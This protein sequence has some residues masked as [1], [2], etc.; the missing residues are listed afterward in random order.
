MTKSLVIRSPI[1]KG[2]SLN[3]YLLRLASINNF[4]GI[5]GIIRKLDQKSTRRLD[6]NALGRLARFTGSSEC[7][8]RTAGYWPRPYAKVTFGSGEVSANDLIYSRP[9]SCSVCFAKSGKHQRL[10]DLKAY[11]VCHRH[12]T[13][14]QDTCERCGAFMSWDR[15]TIDRCTC[16]AYLAAQSTSRSAGDLVNL[17][18]L[19]AELY[20]HGRSSVANPFSD[21]AF[22]A[23]A[24]WIFGS[25]S[26]ST[27]N[28][29]SLYMSKPKVIDA[30]P[31][32]KAGAPVLTMWPEGLQSWLDKRCGGIHSTE[33]THRISH[34]RTI[35]DRLENAMGGPGSSAVFDEIRSHIVSAGYTPG[36]KAKSFWSR[37]NN[38]YLTA[39]AAAKRLNVTNAS[40]KSLLQRRS[41]NGY[42]AK[43]NERTISY[44]ST[45]SVRRYELDLLDVLSPVAA[46]GKLGTSRHQIEKLIRSKLLEPVSQRTYDVAGVELSKF[47]DR[48]VGLAIPHSESPDL[49]R[50]CDIPRLRQIGIP[51]VIRLVLAG[52]IQIYSEKNV[53]VQSLQ[54]LWVAKD[55]LR[56]RRLNADGDEAVSHR[57]AADMLGVNVRMIPILLERGLL[58]RLAGP[59]DAIG[60]PRNSITMSSV[61]EFVQ[62]YVWTR[63]IAK[64]VGT[65]TRSAIDE[66]LHAGEKPI[67]TSDSKAGV[68]ALWRWSALNVLATHR[69]N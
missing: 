49:I 11:V 18:N 2:E 44:V 16:G 28:W 34:F 31:I 43:T 10:W 9:R 39:T 23:S 67:I 36:F 27:E 26:I 37:P 52:T 3:G 25:M 21:L 42:S 35:L 30:L 51:E 47:I 50:V 4:G 57:R 41:L 19:L 29:R 48:I 1:E 33:P 46:A 63:D 32:I 5:R 54:T 8:L 68:S 66:L 38:K 14:L 24:V 6:E 15:C 65:S 62:K 7:A 55:Q 12:S 58:N 17:A 53:S 59:S 22:A 13:V 56:G 45:E 69:R 20:E 60:N 61:V 40:L 64:Q